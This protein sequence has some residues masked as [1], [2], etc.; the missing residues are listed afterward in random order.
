[1]IRKHSLRPLPK[2][3]TKAEKIFHKW[4]VTRDKNICI[5]CHKY[6]NE[7]GHFRHNKLDFDEMNLNCQCVSCN[8]F[9]RGELGIYAIYLIAKYGRKKVDDLVFRSN[10]ESNKKSRSELEEIIKKYSN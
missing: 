9:R 10:T 7:A 8:H 3:K 5:T 1:V 2:L 4:I 6:G